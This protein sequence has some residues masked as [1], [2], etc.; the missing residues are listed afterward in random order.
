MQFFILWT[1][2]PLFA[3]TQLPSR[4][5]LG[6]VKT[7]AFLGNQRNN[8]YFFLRRFADGKYIKR[9]A[10][11]LNGIEQGTNTVAGERNDPAI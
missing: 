4:I 9:V 6:F 2:E 3:T 1:S 8:P 11:A 5:V 7:A 10:M